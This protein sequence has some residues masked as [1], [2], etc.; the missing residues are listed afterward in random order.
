LSSSHFFA[1]LPSSPAFRCIFDR[2]FLSFAQFFSLRCCSASF[3]VERHHKIPRAF[4][5]EED[6]ALEMVE[7]SGGEQHTKPRNAEHDETRGR[8]EGSGGN[9]MCNT[10]KTGEGKEMDN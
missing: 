8:A 9:R 6:R 5:D 4:T 3:L 7:Q 2:L 10:K 1:L